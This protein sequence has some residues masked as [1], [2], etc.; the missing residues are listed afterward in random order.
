[1]FQPSTDQTWQITRLGSEHLAKRLGKLAQRFRPQPGVFPKTDL[2]VTAW[3]ELG[4]KQEKLLDLVDTAPKGEPS[5]QLDVN[6]SS[7]WYFAL[8]R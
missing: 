8:R 6:R 2:G 4:A 1:M 7:T 5:E 3:G